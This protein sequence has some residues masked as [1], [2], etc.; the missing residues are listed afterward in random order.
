MSDKD[1]H[2]PILQSID[3]SDGKDCSV[4]TTYNKQDN[5]ITI[6][7]ITY[8]EPHPVDP[9][10]DRLIEKVAQK[11]QQ[12]IEEEFCKILAPRNQLENNQNTST[13]SSTSTEDICSLFKI[14][15]NRP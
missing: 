11:I 2:F 8:L 7:D 12:R 3:K 13:A 1:Y 9:E 14:N 5:K 10:M 15:G 6:F 4:I